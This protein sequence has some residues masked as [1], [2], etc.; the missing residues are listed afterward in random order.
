LADTAQLNCDFIDNFARSLPPQADAVSTGSLID[1]DIHAQAFPGEDNSTFQAVFDLKTQVHQFLDYERKKHQFGVPQRL[2]QVDEWTVF[3]VSVGLWDLVEY[4]TLEKE[5]ALKAID[6]SVEGL[7][8]NLDLLARHVATPMKVVVPK[9]VDVT[10]LP[11]FQSKKDINK[12]H[13]AEDQHQLVFLWTYWNS[14][15]S[16]TASQWQHGEIFMPNPNNLILDQVRAK[17]MYSTNTYDA[18]GT[19]KQMPLFDYVTEP[20]SKL[21]ENDTARTLQAAGVEKCSKHLFW[22]DLHLS[23]PA[24][25][26]IGKAAASLLRGN[27]T[28]NA[29]DST[30]GP[31]SNNNASE[32]EPASFT[33]KYPPGY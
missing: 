3:T 28:I 6:R 2:R 1:S 32:K 17:Q 5:S 23:G 10:F 15:L 25:Q 27:H 4:A 21:S 11:R 22:D 12:E 24:H 8:E 33:L 20:C 16:R 18:S 29:G 19:G 30:Q 31:D 9:L 26:L 14:V 7:F 13:F